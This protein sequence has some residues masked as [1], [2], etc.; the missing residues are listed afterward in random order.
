MIN[1]YR[2]YILWANISFVCTG[3]A[4]EQKDINKDAAQQL[5]K[6]YSQKENVYQQKKSVQTGA[7]KINPTIERYR[8]RSIIK[9]AKIA[10]ALESDKKRNRFAHG[11]PSLQY[12]CMLKFACA[13]MPLDI[14]RSYLL[15]CSKLEGFEYLK[16]IHDIY[17]NSK[18]ILRN[19]IE[20]KNINWSLVADVLR[21]HTFSDEM[22]TDS[23][24]LLA[25]KNNVED[26]I[27]FTQLVFLIT[28]NNIYKVV[29]DT[30]FSS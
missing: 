29:A 14:K 25:Q 19:F 26:L 6:N 22:L 5:V 28:N 1:R 20:R 11:V 16:V 4:M 2:A 12:Q 13:Q 15:E 24:R 23:A 8:K 10:K 21:A 18:Y 27:S 3:F 9:Y 17:P 30:I 7:Q